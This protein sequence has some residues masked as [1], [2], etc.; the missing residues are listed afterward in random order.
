MHI[1]GTPTC[2]ST[3]FT[4]YSANSQCI[5]WQWVCD[6]DSECGDGSDE[7]TELCRASGKCGGNFTSQSGLI[8]S[9]SFPNKYSNN[10]DCVYIIS[11]PNGSHVS[12]TVVTFSLFYMRC[13]DYL[14]IKDGDSENSKLMGKFCGGNIPQQIKSSKN[15]LRIR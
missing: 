7:S 2:D 5:P 14:E 8:T 6:G 4:C 12:L 10:A 9:P 13:Y 11:Q 15:H 3:Y 1:P